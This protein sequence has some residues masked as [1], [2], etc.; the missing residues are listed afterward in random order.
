MKKVYLHGDLA[1]GIRSEWEL[2]VKSPAEAIRAINI[3][4]LGKLMENI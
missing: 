2:N 3:N 4:C 1:K